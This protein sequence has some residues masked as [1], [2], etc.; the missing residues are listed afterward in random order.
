MGRV[1]RQ[2]Q[3]GKPGSEERIVQLLFA[4]KSC[5]K[6]VDNEGEETEIF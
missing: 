5:E 3:Y 1:F 6:Y 2:N 4:E